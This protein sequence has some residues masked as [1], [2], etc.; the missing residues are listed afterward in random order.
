[1]VKEEFGKETQVLAIYG[2]D[3]AI[4]LIHRKV[5][6]QIDLGPRRSGE[7]AFPSRRKQRRVSG[8]VGRGLP[9]RS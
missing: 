4:D 9:M 8:G 3:F 1:V 5:I 2:I 7:M 6:L